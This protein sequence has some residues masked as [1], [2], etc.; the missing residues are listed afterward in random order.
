MIIPALLRAQTTPGPA[1]VGKKSVI[2]W[3]WA[4]DAQVVAKIEGNLQG[5]DAVLV[6]SAMYGEESARSR[7]LGKVGQVCR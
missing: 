2:I 7:R 3:C 6:R 1:V 5:R 4:A